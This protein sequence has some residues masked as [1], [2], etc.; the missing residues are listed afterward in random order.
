MWLHKLHNLHLHNVPASLPSRQQIQPQHCFLTVSEHRL[1]ES[2]I[3]NEGLV[4]RGQAQGCVAE[5]LGVNPGVAPAARQVLST[6]FWFSTEFLF[7]F[8]FF[9]TV[10]LC[11]IRMEPQALC[12]VGR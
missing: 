9:L 3:L 1:R 11:C 2:Q 8:F 10:L 5:T 4:L 12:M 7:F 6:H